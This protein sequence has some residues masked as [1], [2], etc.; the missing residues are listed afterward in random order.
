MPDPDYSVQSNSGS[1]GQGKSVLGA[2]KVFLVGAG[3][4]DPRLITVRGLQC[5]QM[6]DVILYDGLANL[7]LLEQAPRAEKISV[8][9]HGKDPIWQQST[10]NNRLIELASKG[11]RVV[12]LKGGDP[13]VFARTAEELTAL[14]EHGI[15][16]EVVPGITAALAVASYAGIPLTHRDHASA[17]ALVTAQQQDQPPHD[18]DWR[19]LAQF[20]GTLVVYMGVTTAKQWTNQLILAGKPADTPAA[21]VRRCTWNDQRIIRCPLLEVADH[22]TPASKLRPPVLVVI[23]QAASLGTQWNW[24]ERLPLFGSLVW[25]PGPVGRSEAVQE[26]LMEQ[27]AQVISQPV[28]ELQPPN[29]CG[30]LQ[31]ALQKL[32][33]RELQGIT[34]SSRHG[35]SGFFDYLLSQ[36][37][38]AR[39]LAGVRLAAVGPSVAEQL[40]GYGLRADVIPDQQYSAASLVELLVKQVSGQH[41]LVTTTNRSGDTLERGLLAAGAQ[42]TTCLTYQSVPLQ[43]PGPALVAAAASGNLR[44]VLVSSGAIA[45]GVAKMLSQMPNDATAVVKPI[46]LGQQTAEALRELGLPAVAVSH[47]NSVRSLIDAL[48]GYHQVATNKI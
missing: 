30:Q 22:L 6:A 35:V 21:I 33:H 17:V 12:R 47:S 25:W 5:L 28:I 24:F 34:F 29:D 42:V 39:L 31:G 27:G 44:Y 2:G 46:A 38:D 19:A 3:P 43:R 36:R 16:F 10:I 11:K 13:A 26:H 20:P 40:A 32:L 4:G 45:E 41:W 23:G 9:K 1:A 14:Q 8:G 7:A 18:I 48:V 37:Y 15:A